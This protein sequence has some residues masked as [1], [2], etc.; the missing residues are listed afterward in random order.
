[1]TT[2][3]F[4]RR[5][6]LKY[7][8]PWIEV[9]RAVLVVVEDQERRGDLPRLEHRRVAQV[10]LGLIEEVAGEAALAALEDGL[11]RRAGVPVDRAVH[12]H[13]VG[14]RRAGDRGGEP[15]GLGDQE[16]GLVAA[17][18]VAVEPTCAASTTPDFAAASSAGSTHHA[19]DMPGSLT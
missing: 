19:A 10:R 18:G 16:R 4:R 3:F 1:M 13:Q 11:V 17:P 7:S 6:M 5:R 2:G 12:A 14:E 15:V 8:M 9:D